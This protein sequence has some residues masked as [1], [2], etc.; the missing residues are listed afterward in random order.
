LDGTGNPWFR[1]D[2]GIDGRRIVE[3]GN[4]PFPV[5]DLFQKLEENGM[6]VNFGCLVGHNTV[7]RE[8]MGLPYTMHASDGSVRVLGRGVPHPRNYGTFPHVIA[9]YVREKGIITIAEAVRK[10]TSL[11]AQVF[12]IRERG[13]LREGMYADI[14]VFDYKALRDQATFAEPHQYAQGL[15]SVIV[16]GQVVVNDGTHTGKLPGM[17][18]YGFGKKQEAENDSQD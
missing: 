17:I 3:I 6:S 15:R 4:H 9:R 11:P 14:T 5:A 7:R 8:V 12:P 1:A 13:M 2:I 10:M 18:I 16:N